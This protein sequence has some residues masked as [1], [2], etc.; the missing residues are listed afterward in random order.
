MILEMR[1]ENIDFMLVC[2]HNNSYLGCYKFE[3]SILFKLS[4]TTSNSLIRYTVCYSKVTSSRDISNFA[5]IPPKYSSAL[6]VLFLM[7]QLHS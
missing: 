6:F 5:C 7:F 3:T 1:E 2:L 4:K